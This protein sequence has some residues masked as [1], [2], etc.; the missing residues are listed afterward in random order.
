LLLSL[1]RALAAG[2]EKKE[3]RIQNPEFSLENAGHAPIPTDSILLAPEFPSFP[4][5]CG[6]LR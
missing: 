6:A 5:G 4:A 3:C 2:G 1:E